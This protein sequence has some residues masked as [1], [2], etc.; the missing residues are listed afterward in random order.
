MIMKKQDQPR[1]TALVLFP[2]DQF[3]MGGLR[4][5]ACRLDEPLE[6]GL[7]QRLGVPAN[8]LREIDENDDLVRPVGR[9]LRRCLAGCSQKAPCHHDRCGDR[10]P[11]ALSVPIRLHRASTLGLSVK[12]QAT[13]PAG[14]TPGPS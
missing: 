10:H 13:S 11:P 3:A 4:L 8:A 9:E 6:V 7:E 5:S 2:L 1:R 14:E 12:S